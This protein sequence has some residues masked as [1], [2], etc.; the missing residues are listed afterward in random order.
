MSALSRFFKKIDEGTD[1]FLAMPFPWKVLV[2]MTLFVLPVPF[3]HIL[4]PA[5]YT[6]TA[7]LAST[8][9]EGLYIV[10]N[11]LLIT[12]IMAAL[13]AIVLGPFMFSAALRAKRPMLHRRLGKIYVTGCM[14]SAVSVFP[15][16]L[17]NG[18]GPVAW[19]GFGVMATL[20]FTFTWLGY[21]AARNKDFPAHRRWLMRSYAMTFAFVHV[22]LTY[23]LLLPYDLLSEESIKVFQSMVSWMTNLMIAE[24]YLAGTTHGGKFIGL[25]KWAGNMLQYC[26]VDRFHWNVR[27]A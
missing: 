3:I 11:L 18:V 27:K 22:N 24:I 2:V 1:Y 25:R 5:K 9:L 8:F 17:S 20:W 7:G 15:L 10:N 12:H 19:L 4:N 6:N 21:C 23:R 13:P 26:P 14:V 16:A